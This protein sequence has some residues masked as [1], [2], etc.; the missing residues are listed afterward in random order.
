MVKDERLDMTF[1]DVFILCM[2]SVIVFFGLIGIVITVKHLNDER[3]KK[4]G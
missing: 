2:L 3:N 1:D 4:D